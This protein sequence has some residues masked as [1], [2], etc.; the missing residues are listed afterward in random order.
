MAA[1]SFRATPEASPPGRFG[2][3]ADFA[4]QRIGKLAAPQ[5]AL[6]E[7]LNVGRGVGQLPGA[8]VPEVRVDQ[9]D[10]KA[11]VVPHVPHSTARALRYMS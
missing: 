11:Q 7:A 9:G 10:A 8:R 6:P 1:R 3:D 2:N 5:V 4:R